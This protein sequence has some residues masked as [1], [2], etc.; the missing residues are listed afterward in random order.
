MKSG[1]FLTLKPLAVLVVMSLTWVANAAPGSTVSFI[2]DVNSKKTS[3]NLGLKENLS[4]VIKIHF[5]WASW[6]E[7]CEEAYS[8]LDKI[9]SDPA[10]KGKIEVRGYCLDENITKSVQAKIS[11][12]PHVVHYQV[13]RKSLHFPEGLERFPLA[14]LED[15]KSSKMDVFT[16]FSKER[17][18]YLKR[19]IQKLIQTG[20]GDDNQE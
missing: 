15:S 20:V 14:I 10:L 5:F 18:H 19:S 1:T 9:Q 8:A 16:G 2:N 12:M 11:E 17:Y 4:A 13:S 3:L 7:Y 6:C